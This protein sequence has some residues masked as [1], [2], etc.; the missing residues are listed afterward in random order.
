MAF[1]L[2]WIALLA[3]VN[4]GKRRGRWLLGLPDRLFRYAA[5]NPV[6]A[7]GYGTLRPSQ[8]QRLR[9][10]ELA[11][12]PRIVRVHGPEVLHARL[13]KAAA[14]VPATGFPATR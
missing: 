10:F 14:R 8:N 6:I 11:G 9:E 7:A 5:L 1:F 4:A 13:P 3:R 12:Q 2:L